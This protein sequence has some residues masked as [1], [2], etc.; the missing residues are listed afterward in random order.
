MATLDKAR[1][2]GKGAPCAAASVC[3]SASSSESASACASA[4]AS[5]RGL[6][7]R[8]TNDYRR[9]ESTTRG[10]MILIIAKN[11]CD[12]RSLP[13]ATPTPTTLQQ[14]RPEAEHDF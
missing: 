4:S 10:T 14:R 13:M 3:V 2:R 1:E 7:K 12:V 8:L 11:V 5:A 9:Q 6:R